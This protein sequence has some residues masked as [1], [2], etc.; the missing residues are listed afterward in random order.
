MLV[1]PPF[2][3]R[4][5]LPDQPAMTRASRHAML[6][7][8]LALTLSCTVIGSC[9]ENMTRWWRSSDRYT[10]WQLATG[11]SFLHLELHRRMAFRII[12]KIRR[13]S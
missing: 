7:V 10:L 13:A 12:A 11:S 4:S 6:Q 8:C 5:H 1:A 9:M 3:S 2:R